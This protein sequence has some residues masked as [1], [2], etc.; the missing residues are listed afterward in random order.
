MEDRWLSVDE[1][2][3]YLGV[4]PDTV[5][6]WVR[7]MGMPAHKVGRLLKF[8]AAEIDDWVRSGGSADKAG[9]KTGEND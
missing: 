8:K 9:A 4:Q 7:R 5:Y 1:I 2:A 6:K 3:E